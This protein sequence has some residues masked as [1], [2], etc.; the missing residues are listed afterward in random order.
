M[1]SSMGRCSVVG[2]APAQFL[3]TATSMTHF[4]N[5]PLFTPDKVPLPR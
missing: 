5:P 2:K 1:A 3:Q 4:Y